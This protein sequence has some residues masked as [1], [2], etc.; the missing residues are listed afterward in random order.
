[1]AIEVKVAGN[2]PT[3]Y[4]IY[5]RPY[6][7]E[8]LATVHEWFDLV[9][10][11]ASIKEYADPVID[12]L[13][14][15]VLSHKIMKKRIKKMNSTPTAI[16]QKRY[17]RGSCIFIDGKGYVKDLSVLLKNE[18]SLMNKM[19]TPTKIPK[20][21]KPLDYSKVII[22][23][24]SPISYV[25]HQNNGLMIEGWINDPDDTELLNLLPLLN[26]L[27][28]VSD[29]RCVLGLKEGQKVFS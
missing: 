13:E 10:F 3:L 21:S 6:V 28:F 20:N 14:Q 7:E 25:K 1:M 8:F 22:I 24:N 19:R 26:S 27:R 16:F 11:T 15:E 18:S 2:L 5:K 29:V 4:H 23:D 12:Y 17:Y 9:C